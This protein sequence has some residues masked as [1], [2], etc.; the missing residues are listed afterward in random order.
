MTHQH[1]HT[2]GFLSNTA[3]KACMLK[4]C[5]RVCPGCCCF[6]PALLCRINTG[7]AAFGRN[8]SMPPCTTVSA[9]YSNEHLRER[10]HLGLVLLQALVDGQHVAERL[11]VA[12]PRGG[13][14]AGRQPGALLLQQPVLLQGNTDNPPS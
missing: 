8:S 14:Q 2:E 11:P 4:P 1:V 9:L 6:F 10:E 13:R 3:N 12:A 7:R 5:V